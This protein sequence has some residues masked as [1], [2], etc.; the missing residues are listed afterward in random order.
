MG[1]HQLKQLASSLFNF[2]FVLPSPQPLPRTEE[3]AQDQQDMAEVAQLV[4]EALQDINKLEAGAD[5]HQ[6]DIDAFAKNVIEA[7]LE[8]TD[9]SIGDA[10][11]DAL[12]YDQVYEEAQELPY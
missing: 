6:D 3:N 8:E 5:L 4:T 10:I 1:L 12:V 2:L 9:A 7:E 11:A